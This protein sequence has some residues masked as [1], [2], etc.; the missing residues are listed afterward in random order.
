MTA[1][2]GNSSRAAQPQLLGSSP[3]I[4]TVRY[5]VREVA[6][7]TASCLVTGPS[8]SGKEVVAGLLHAS[9]PRAEKPFVPVNCGAIPRE[10]I[11]SELF[12]HEKGAFTGAVTH[13]TGRF[14]ASHGGTLF[15]D[16]IGDMPA[17]VQVKLLRILEE[18][19]FER[20]GSNRTI[21]FDSRIVAA[22]HRDLPA[23]IA[24]NEFREDLYY[25]LNIFPIHLPP[26]CARREDVAELAAHFALTLGGGTPAF[27][28]GPAATQLLSEYDWPGN[29]RELR[30]WAER[31]AVLY[32]GKRVD[33]AGAE[34]LLSLGRMRAQVD[35][36]MPVTPVQRAATQPTL[37]SAPPAPQNEAARGELCAAEGAESRAVSL[38][39]AEEPQT[40][41]AFGAANGDAGP[42]HPFG[43][44]A[45]SDGRAGDA[46]SGGVQKDEQHAHTACRDNDVPASGEGSNIMPLV[47]PRRNGAAPPAAQGAGPEAL[48]AS[49]D[50]DLKQL[51]GEMEIGYIRAALERSD[52]V[53]ADA[54]RMLSLRRT[55]LCEK[56]KKYGLGRTSEAAA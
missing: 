49:G 20:I 26:L 2:S 14:E 32:R 44:A 51:L 30:N 29:V 19:R 7:S 40:L 38:Y 35:A 37:P 10:L 55:T 24:A 41:P 33:A 12:G 56:I 31:A 42:G 11:E 34:F 47:L 25:R 52:H 16:E 48:L 50:V 53:I 39:A 5:F 22:T 21:E 46:V 13:R 6:D 36:A 27:D 1:L 45:A 3:A 43:R 15:L 54:A 18:R 4:E 28:L 23:R 9:S 8:G 17:D